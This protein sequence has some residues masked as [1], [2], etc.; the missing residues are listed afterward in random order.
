MSAE[1]VALVRR[2]FEEVWND[3]R[4]EAID[5]LLDDESFCTADT[6]DMLGPAGFR[7]IQYEPM[8]AAFPDARVTI[9]GIM[10]AGDEVAVR[11]SAD[12]THTGEAMGMT[13]TGRP[14]RL[15]GVSWIK[16][17][18]GKLG[19]GWQWSNIPTVLASL[20]Q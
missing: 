13:P 17:R 7:A 19:L 15:E 11:W 16:V 9:E 8:L 6:G 12:A 4:A 1:N 14:V 10:A 20:R 2:F 5:E 18:D 3:R